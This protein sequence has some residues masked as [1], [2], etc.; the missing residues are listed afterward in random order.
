MGGGILQI[1]ANSVSNSIFNDVNYSFFKIV[2]HK[3]TSFTIEDYIL[4]LSGLSDFG[5]KLEVVIPKVGD[6]LTDI[7]LKVELPQ[8]KGEYVFSDKDAY[9]ASLKAQ[10]TFVTMTDIQQ[11]NENLY[12]ESLGNGMQVYLIRNYKDN[13]KGTVGNY[14]LMLPLL[15]ST[16]F[17]NQG[18]SQPYSLQKYLSD[19]YPT[20][21]G[22]SPNST[23]F[24]NQ[25][26][27]HTI[28][29]LLYSLKSTTNIDYLNYAFQDKEFYFFI[30]NLLNIKEINPSYKITYFNEWQNNYY[31]TVKK[32]ILKTPEIAS[33]NTFIENM[34]T[35]LTDSTTT[36]NYVFNYNN[37][38]TVPPLDYQYKIV[39]PSTF[40]T[41]YYLSYLPPSTNNNIYSFFTIFNRNYILVKR[42][43]VIIGAVVI[44]TVL[45]TSPVTLTVYPFRHITT[46]KVIETYGDQ[47]YLYYGFEGS[48]LQPINFAMINNI[49][50]NINN[51]QEF[52]LDRSI[53]INI[54][55]VIIIG[56]NNLL[57]KSYNVVYGVFKVIQ[58]SKSNTGI[59]NYSLSN[60][61]TVLTVQPIEI[62]QLNLTDTLLFNSNSNSDFN[63]FIYYYNDTFSSYNTYQNQYTAVNLLKSIIYTD[64]LM[65][66]IISTPIISVS[67][68]LLK[69]IVSANDFVLNSTKI[70]TIQNNIQ[71]YITDSYDVLFNYMNLIYFKTIIKDPDNH[72]YLNNFYFKLNYQQSDSLFVLDG[73]GNS[74]FTNLV[75]NVLRYQQYLT[76]TINNSLNPSAVLN[77]TNFLTTYIINQYQTT[78]TLFYN[79]WSADLLQ[80]KDKLSD[81]L[82]K[83][84]NY[85]QYGTSGRRTFLTFTTNTVPFTLLNLI[86]LTLTYKFNNV[87]QTI[88]IPNNLINITTNT[89]AFDLTQLILSLHI[90]FN[91]QYIDFNSAYFTYSYTNSV[92]VIVNGKL[93][94]TNLTSYMDNYL[95]DIL[96]IINNNT[97]I[98]KQLYGNNILLDFINNLYDEMFNYLKNYEI[99]RKSI[100]RNSGILYTTYQEDT[101][102]Q[103]PLLQN[104]TYLIKYNSDNYFSRYLY[105]KQSQLYQNIY[106][107]VNELSQNYSVETSSI[108]FL[109]NLN[110][111]RTDGYNYTFT[112]EGSIPFLDPQQIPLLIEPNSYGDNLL[113]KVSKYNILITDTSLYFTFSSFLTELEEHVNSTARYDPSSSPVYYQ[114]PF[115]EYYWRNYFTING[116][117]D[118]TINNYIIGISGKDDGLYLYYSYR[119]LSELYA[120]YNDMFN[121]NIN[122]DGTNFN[123]IYELSP[124][125]LSILMFNVMKSVL[126]TTTYSTSNI[127]YY[128]TYNNIIQGV[129]TLSSIYT[130]NPLLPQYD[131]SATFPRFNTD[132]YNI[133]IEISNIF[134]II[135]KLTLRYKINM[136]LSSSITLSTYPII[137][138]IQGTGKMVK[139]ILQSDQLAYY[140]PYDKR[141]Y[142]PVVYTTGYTV[143]EYYKVFNLSIHYDYL[144]YLFFGG[145]GGM[146]NDNLYNIFAPPMY[147]FFVKI[148]SFLPFFGS[149]VTWEDVPVTYA[150]QTGLYLPNMEG[151]IVQSYQAWINRSA[152]PYFYYFNALGGYYNIMYNGYLGNKFISEY[153]TTTSNQ[154]SYNNRPDIF[155]GELVYATRMAYG[156]RDSINRLSGNSLRY[157]LLDQRLY[158]IIDTFTS[159]NPTNDSTQYVN[160]LNNLNRR[161]TDYQEF[162]VQVKYSM[163]Q[164]SMYAN[165]DLYST[166]LT[167][168]KVNNISMTDLQIFNNWNTY[169]LNFNYNFSPILS[170]LNNTIIQYNQLNSNILDLS[171]LGYELN[172]FINNFNTRYQI[173]FDDVLALRY[174]N[175]IDDYNSIFSGLT[176]FTEKDTFTSNIAYR[177]NNYTLIQF[178]F[179]ALPI[180]NIMGLYQSDISAF[181]QLF[182]IMLGN[183]QKNTSGTVLPANIIAKY[184]QYYTI[185]DVTSI[186]FYDKYFKFSNSV[187]YN[188]MPLIYHDLYNIQNASHTVVFYLNYLYTYLSS[189]STKPNIKDYD[190]PSL[191][192]SYYFP[193]YLSTGI[194]YFSQNF[195]SLIV[196]NTLFYPLKQLSQYEGIQLIPYYVNVYNLPVPTI[197]YT[198][199]APANPVRP[200]SFMYLFLLY[201]IQYRNYNYNF[202]GDAFLYQSINDYYGNPVRN[203]TALNTFSTYSNINADVR[204]FD[205]LV[206]S[207]AITGKIDVLQNVVHPFFINKHIDNLLFI[208]DLLNDLTTVPDNAPLNYILPNNSN[209]INFLNNKTIIT[210]TFDQSG[211]ING[212]Y[213]Y[214][215]GVLS[216]NNYMGFIPMTDQNTDIIRC[217]IEGNIKLPYLIYQIYYFLTSECFLLNQNELIA[218]SY[219]NTPMYMGNLL[220][221]VTAVQWKSGLI[222]LISEY[223]FLILKSKNIIYQNS[224][225]EI[226]YYDLYT[227]IKNFT[228]IDRLIDIVD[229]Y[230]NSIVN[231]TINRNVYNAV[232]KQFKIADEFSL[233][234]IKNNLNYSNYYRLLFALRQSLIGKYNN[235]NERVQFHNNYDYW[236][237][238]NIIL[239]SEYQSI[240]LNNINYLIK[241]IDNSQMYSGYEYYFNNTINIPINLFTTIVDYI[242]LNIYNS[243]Y[244]KT[245]ATNTKYNFL[246][247]Q[248]QYFG[249][250]A[251][252]TLTNIYFDHPNN[253]F[254]IVIDT[255]AKTIT[256]TYTGTAYTTGY[257][258]PF[259][260]VYNSLPFGY[261][262]NFNN[263]T[264]RYQ[265]LL[266]QTASPID[267]NDVGILQNMFS[268]Y[269]NIQNISETMGIL[270]SYS[271]TGNYNII[272]SVNRS[273]YNFINF[274]TFIEAFINYNYIALNT[275][276]RVVTF[277]IS[278]TI[279]V[280]NIVITY[281]FTFNNWSEFY[282]T[283][284]YAYFNYL[285]N[286]YVPTSADYINIIPLTNVNG[287]WIGS[288]DFSFAIPGSNY[289]SITNVL[290]DDINYTFGTVPVAVTINNP[291]IVSTIDR[292]TL[293]NTNAINKIP[294]FNKIGLPTWLSSYTATQLWVYVSP[295][296]DYTNITNALNNGSGIGNGPFLIMNYIDQNGNKNYYID[297][298]ITYKATGSTY[299]LW[300][301]VADVGT[302][303]DLPDATTFALVSGVPLYSQKVTVRTD[304]KSESTLGNL[305]TNNFAIAVPNIS[306]TFKLNQ[307]Y[308]YSYYNITQLYLYISTDL[309]TN[310]NPTLTNQNGVAWQPVT[311]SAININNLATFTTTFTVPNNNYYI[312]LSYNLIT[313]S[314]QWKTNP[315][316]FSLNLLNPPYPTIPPSPP[317]AYTPF[318]LSVEQLNGGSR[319]NNYVYIYDPAHPVPDPNPNNYSLQLYQ[320]IGL[321]NSLGITQ[322]YVYI[323]GNGD[324]SYTSYYPI[325]GVEEPITLVYNFETNSIYLNFSLLLDNSYL[326]VNQNVYIT[327]NP[328]YADNI[329]FG[330][331]AVNIQIT[332][333]PFSYPY[334]N[335]TFIDVVNPVISTFDHVPTDL[336]TYQ[337]NPIQVNIQ[338]YSTHY[339]YSNPNYDPTDPHYHLWI[340]L[341]SSDDPGSIYFTQINEIIFTSPFTSGYFI[342]DCLT[343]SVEPAWTFISN[344]LT[345]GS[346]LINNSIGYLYNII[347]SINATI[348]PY[349]YNPGDITSFDIL[350]SQWDPTYISVNNITSLYIYLYGTSLNNSLQLGPFD[351]IVT[352]TNDLLFIIDPSDP[353]NN[354]NT[355]NQDTYNIYISDVS[356]N[357]EDPPTLPT[358]PPPNGYIYQ[359][360]TNQLTIGNITIQYLNATLSPIIYG[361]NTLE[362]LDILLTLWQINYSNVVTQVYVY[363]YGTTLNQT[364]T[365]GPYTITDTLTFNILFTETLTGLDPDTYDIY[366]SDDINNFTNPPTTPT[367]PPTS[368]YLYQQLSTQLTILNVLVQQV[369]ASISP[370]TYTNNT[371]ESFDILL[372]LW[373]LNYSTYVTQ[374]YVYLY[375]ST[376]NQTLTLGPYFITPTLTPTYDILF[377]ET[378]SGLDPDTY[379]IYISD[380][381]LNFTNP[382]TAPN[383]PPT[384]GYIYQLLSNQLTIN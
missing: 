32:Y 371:V 297:T 319:S 347:G 306:Q 7:I 320:E 294:T 68:T 110:Y 91:L 329:P 145:Y 116:V 211:L 51:Y 117:N 19:V 283:N 24:T 140:F 336:I 251:T 281:E 157:N 123:T 147:A 4:P 296:N 339:E 109:N 15:D 240:T 175:I 260:I 41:N 233:T 57:T 38:F 241:T 20:S 246:N 272:S 238:N 236:N 66:S 189:T 356:T 56:I 170:G 149:G 301:Y 237:S 2:Y 298:T 120:L 42:N 290:L 161:F 148:N 367:I 136:V 334:T 8:V 200:N 365:L 194:N 205:R 223:L 350:L 113:N 264:V 363:F 65:V 222:N 255:G 299:N 235:F 141:F 45:D 256:G 125:S 274:S 218:S 72:D 162:L 273:Y 288:L 134:Q 153:Y 129:N 105:S 209:Y 81:N 164:T 220:G 178:D 322:L 48:Q 80:I 183:R 381:V 302:V 106:Q 295:N 143:D 128:Q 182:T 269:K 28:I 64:V 146:L 328:I 11:Y 362:S 193:R 179:S 368:G 159:T 176:Y 17:L 108:Y 359:L 202:I 248:Y 204:A 326:G 311:G 39:L 379:D 349:I 303:A 384:N 340:F 271:V 127:D 130:S 337:T 216:T 150:N 58:V 263:S 118:T 192:Y 197:Y 198:T 214:T 71:T 276:P 77:Y 151:H 267:S 112:S 132:I 156:S 372:P 245:G 196:D 287:Q 155:Q 139:I 265:Q 26:K 158:G 353:V 341:G 50:L 382:P 249:Y 231:I 133:V 40:D 332:A 187:D 300:L 99:S 186:T 76:N 225:S 239:S 52:T 369:N 75:N 60:Y 122:I 358:V 83:I 199:P 31:N 44:K 279:T 181:K 268:V 98:T 344:N 92:P 9:L 111:P 258:Q 244:N 166:L 375:G 309:P 46:N 208:K 3:Y 247:F 93:N 305:G 101:I 229:M 16:M 188:L 55:D 73:V 23:Y 333:P 270:L 324:G 14:Q 115:Q 69:Q 228:S 104:N 360:L 262:F 87:Q 138:K 43:G 318:R 62:D 224:I 254:R 144:K 314:G 154:T 277:T 252:L 354:F 171:S 253:T 27:L 312:Y 378:L 124:N 357:F 307:P 126:D 95:N 137:Y 89:V 232:Y 185:N 285:N 250:A 289:I 78:S 243:I 49:K 21:T 330:Q 317:P 1:A 152:Q 383:I 280:A 261:Q 167:Q 63:T 47:L 284:A 286:T 373:D 160:L 207:L 180:S 88:T 361:T 119:Y 107:K 217:Y 219:Q 266:Y 310:P 18:I 84:L 103:N 321:W 293:S 257:N 25:F 79:Q 213:P 323:T 291:I 348:S 275:V 308:W 184:N 165:N 100:I 377:T 61:N 102:D 376:L 304:I 163:G 54:D 190:N 90:P 169:V 85:V 242:I 70:T 327:Y 121:L 168:F 315:V 131:T 177:N 325:N 10:Y 227:R 30:A 114:Q 226:S 33:L 203:I 37:L 210:N 97:P 370:N 215:L 12:K 345:Y 221:Q 53:D 331:G 234:S 346:G 282:G 278:P 364:L 259:T 173:N 5:K 22:T 351:V 201:K 13:I 96:S 338:N 355:L 212:G 191:P 380:D 195:H 172:N 342:Y 335:Y 313:G 74:N 316:N 206:D 35:E 6:L 142:S 374:V 343:T 59:D 29:P 36:N 34:N 86:S 135:T 366:I 292:G 94:I 67:E 230:I 352:G 174:L 82:V